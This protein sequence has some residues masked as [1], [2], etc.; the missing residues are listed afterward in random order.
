MDLGGLRERDRLAVCYDDDDG[1]LHDRVLLAQT[2]RSKWIVATPH[3]DI[4]EE[5]MEDYSLL[6]R[7]GE[8]GGV[9]PRY[10][11][12]RRVRFDQGELRSE[13][14]EAIA[15]ARSQA[16]SLRAAGFVPNG[17]TTAPPDLAAEA[18][19]DVSTDVHLGM[20]CH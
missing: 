8:L 9:G 2:S 6:I 20:G 1:Y 3:W 5:N 7:A 11:G 15:E 13:L 18:A 4:Y 12:M 16:E 14:D 10:S 19:A 17:A